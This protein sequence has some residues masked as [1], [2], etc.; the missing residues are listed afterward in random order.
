MTA[1]C[2]DRERTPPSQVQLQAAQVPQSAHL[3]SD[4]SQG[5]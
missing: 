1:I 3:Q 2:R 5:I 4:L